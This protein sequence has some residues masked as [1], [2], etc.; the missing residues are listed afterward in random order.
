MNK[1]ILK[2]VRKMSEINLQKIAE[3]KREYERQIQEAGQGLFA[4]EFKNFFAAHPEVR[5]LR[6]TQGTPSFNDGDA[7]VFSVYDMHVQLHDTTIR[8]QWV[9]A[10]E[11]YDP[12]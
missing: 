9:D 5:V 1:T 2:K 8:P 7:C 12:D 10:D 3:M 6:W 11:E 4:V